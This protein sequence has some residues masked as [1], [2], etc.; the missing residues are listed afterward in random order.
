MKSATP[1]LLMELGGRPVIV[2]TINTILS[3]P[4][5]KGVVIPTSEENREI[6]VELLGKLSPL[7]EVI[8]G[9]ATRTESVRKGLNN[10]V[11]KASADDLVVVHDGARCFADEELF[12]Q[13]ID[14]ATKTGAA[15]AAVPVVDT[16]KFV[17]DGVITGEVDRSSLWSIQ[18]PQIFRF[19]LLLKAH[20]GEVQATDDASLVEKIQPVQVVEGSRF[21]FK[22]TT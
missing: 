12:R 1:K 17:K 9:G 8:I 13:V 7:I 21:N 4:N 18:T 20:Q 14:A 11:D 15:T 2:R 19:D 22:L 3:I 10:L 5:L 16:M 6:F